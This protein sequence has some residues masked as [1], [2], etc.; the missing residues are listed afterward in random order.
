MNKKSD[1][2]I[3]IVDEFVE[4]FQN[5]YDCVAILDGS[6]NNREHIYNFSDIDIKIFADPEII[7]K[8]F[9]ADVAT[10]IKESLGQEKMVFNAWVLSTEDFPNKQDGVYFDFVRRFV[11]KKE[12][13]LFGNLD[14]ESIILKKEIDKMD[15]DVCI[16]AIVGFLIRLRRLLTNPMAISDVKKIDNHLLL[17][18]GI[19]YYFHFLRY[20]NA[21]FGNVVLKIKDSVN[22]Y[23]NNELTSKSR[24]V[25]AEKVY[26][27]RN[28]WDRTL[29][30]YDQAEGLSFLNEVVGHME[31]VLDHSL[32]PNLGLNN[33]L[34]TYY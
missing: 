12:Q 19:A 1:I 29:K 18:Q 20:Y 16:K 8:D 34:I 5:R 32:R 3:K 13:L 7:N 26:N 9:F 21:F 11:L 22:F 25:F 10:A 27:M 4:N 6:V 33:Q 23:I 24:S 31:F 17:Q 2:F 15:R 14:M 30:I 28:E